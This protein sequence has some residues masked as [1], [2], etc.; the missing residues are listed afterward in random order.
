[1]LLLG[2][3]FALGFDTVTEIGLLGISGAQAGQ[4]MSIWLIM[5]SPAGANTFVYAFHAG[6]LGRELTGPDCRRAAS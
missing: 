4:G 5:P 1:M 2:F 6:A 3:L